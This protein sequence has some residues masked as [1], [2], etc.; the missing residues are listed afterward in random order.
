MVSGELWC[1]H[2][3][4]QT[5]LK[6]A[7]GFKKL[8][9][10][11][12][13]HPSEFF[14]IHIFRGNIFRSGEGGASVSILGGKNDEAS[15]KQYNELFNQLFNQG[16]LNDYIIE[17]SP[18]LKVKD[19]RGKMVIFRR[20]RIDFAHIHKAGNLN[21][22]PG[23]AD[24]WTA[25]QKTA[26]VLDSDPSVKGVMRVTDV[27]SPDNATELQTE[28]NSIKGLFEWQCN[29]TLPNDAKRNGSY[30]PDWS[31]IFTS[32]AYGGENTSGYKKNAA[33]TNPYF[34]NLI[35]TA[36]KK[37]PTGIV[38]SDWVL[39]DNYSAQG[40]ALVPAI[41][42]NNFDYISDYILDD[43]L[44]AKPDA[45][46]YWED[47][48]EYFLR[49][50]G[51]GEFL[52]VGATWG[53][54]AAMSSNEGLPVKLK[55]N[56][57]DGTYYIQT[58]LNSNGMGYDG[59]G[60]YMDYGNLEPFEAKRISS[61]KFNFI[62]T[63]W[64]GENDQTLALG[65]Q[66]VDVDWVTNWSESYKLEYTDGT[67]NVAH[68]LSYD[69]EDPMQQ[70]EIISV[71]DYF[72][73]ETKKASK[74]NPVNISY[75][76][77]GHKVIP[78]DTKN[79]TGQT[80]SYTSWGAKVYSY[81]NYSGKDSKQEK[82]L[83]IHFTHT[84]YST[85]G[86]KS[87][88]KWSM[89]HSI[90]VQKEGAYK[91]RFKTGYDKINTS[92]NEFVF[93]INNEDIRSKLKDVGTNDPASVIDKFKSNEY[94]LEFDYLFDQ[95]G[96]IVFDMSYEGGKTITSVFLDDIELIYYG[97]IYPILERA[98]KDAK[99]R[100]GETPDWLATYENNMNNLVYDR[101]DEGAAPA[102]E[103]YQK[104]RELTLAQTPDDS[105]H[106]DY[107]NA[108]INA[109]FETGTLMG[110]ETSYTG[111]GHDTGV[112]PNEGVYVTQGGQNT[113][114]FNCWQEDPNP[115][116]RGRGVI[117]SQTIPGLPAGHYMVTAQAANDEGDCMY[118]EVNGQRSDALVVEYANNV[119]KLI[120][121]EFEVAENTEEVT[122]SF[123]GG[124]S[125]GSFD[126]YGGNWYKVDDIH[127]Y[128]SGS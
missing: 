22:W 98:I 108:F 10:Y 113:F 126:D 4:D 35:K 31:I 64:K 109:G 116:N 28:L 80:S 75:M 11:L 87:G 24:A 38:L 53:T 96:E 25:D 57:D 52:S 37:G 45:E 61:G 110:W 78:G 41:I 6:L 14:V 15:Q 3:T 91:L 48:K 65:V 42:D 67:K 59:A 112:K 92:N 76:V 27:S 72:E 79:W 106:Q 62:L 127:L 55:F 1:N 77:D 128:R 39:T 58:S 46:K 90:P 81:I 70:W 44:F 99:R 18:Y 7:D 122:I 20:D 2:G 124:N 117:L 36:A 26:V 121:F 56:E 111:E 114:L 102:L 12:D 89:K 40:V 107:T 93:K 68:P 95:P 30:K 85:S 43:I 118:I 69:P 13:A 82:N 23:D 34:T 60:Y 47:G 21:N 49:N 119:S 63:A 123:M 50:V 66:S 19:I 54:R 9:N 71:E 32:G 86:Q 105:K 103:I 17:Y 94:T 101:A 100:L 33:E 73:N 51:T 83:L 8:T 88:T 97:P 5:K 16:W 125:D 84:T 74:N 29:Q 104:M 115:D 120:S